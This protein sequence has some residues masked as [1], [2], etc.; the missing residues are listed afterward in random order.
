MNSIGNLLK[1]HREISGL[2][3][4][5]LAKITG[6]P[7]STI[8]R[9]ENDNNQKMDMS[10]LMTIAKA[11]NISPDAITEM[12]SDNKGNSM[13]RLPILGRVC[14]GTG[15]IAEEDILGYMVADGKYANDEHFCLQVT[16][17]SMSPK[18]DD[19]SIVLVKRQDYAESGD[20]VVAI[21]DE[22]DSMI[23]Q[24]EYSEDKLT[25]VSFNHFYPPRIFAKEDM[26][27]VKIIG[28]VLQSTKMW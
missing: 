19:G 28:K 17:D 10:K 15:K 18:I 23:K 20:V 13:V 8:N 24:I 12:W 7:K 6:I 27:R 26:N 5:G 4:D 16:G 3:L 11:L 22:E 2:S 9:Y 21:V 14:A 25:L 1:R